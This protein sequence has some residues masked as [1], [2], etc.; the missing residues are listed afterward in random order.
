MKQIMMFA[1]I[2]LRHNTSLFGAVLFLMSVN[3]QFMHV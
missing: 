2:T 1:S 3:V